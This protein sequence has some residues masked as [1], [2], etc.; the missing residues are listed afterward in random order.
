ML[1]TTGEMGTVADGDVGFNVLRC[2]AD[3]IIR[4][5]KMGTEAD[6]YIYK[7][8]YQLSSKT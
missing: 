3:I 1:S 2:Q 6:C 8:Y 5:N 4:D 7:I